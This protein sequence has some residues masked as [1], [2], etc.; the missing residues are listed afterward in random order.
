MNFHFSMQKIPGRAAQLTFGFV[1]VLSG[2][3]MENS[4]ADNIVAF[5]LNHSDVNA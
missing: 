5:L 2:H 3:G 4:I 1:A